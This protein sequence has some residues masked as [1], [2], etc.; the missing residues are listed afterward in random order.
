[1]DFVEIK[2]KHNYRTNNDIEDD[3]LLTIPTTAFNKIAN[4]KTNQ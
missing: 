2:P 1:V 4:P 3:H